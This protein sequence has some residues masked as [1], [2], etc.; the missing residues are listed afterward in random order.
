MSC[1][2]FSSLLDIFA[3]LQ[4]TYVNLQAPIIKEKY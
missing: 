1:V 2:I 4:V 3:Q